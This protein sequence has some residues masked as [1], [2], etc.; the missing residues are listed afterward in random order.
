MRGVNDPRQLAPSHLRKEEHNMTGKHKEVLWGQ[1]YY[2]E[3]GKTKGSVQAGKNRTT[4]A[5]IIGA[6]AIRHRG[7]TALLG[8]EKLPAHLNR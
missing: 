7:L 1:I 8:I 3:I 4:D 5:F 6:A 2:C